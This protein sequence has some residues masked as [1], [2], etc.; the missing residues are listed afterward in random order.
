MSVWR[1][2]LFSITEVLHFQPSQCRHRRDHR[3]VSSLPPSL[4]SLPL[5]QPL[6]EPPGREGG[7][8]SIIN[9]SRAVLPPA[10]LLPTTLIEKRTYSSLQKNCDISVVSA[11]IWTPFSTFY[12][13]KIIRQRCFIIVKKLHCRFIAEELSTSYFVINVEF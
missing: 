1:S 9:I 10:S 8:I 6:P 4:L 7:S 13:S 5:P 3:H 12:S 11:S 2:A